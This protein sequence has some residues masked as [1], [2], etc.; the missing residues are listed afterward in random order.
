MAK[1]KKLPLE[2]EEAMLT[3]LEYGHEAA[4]GLA[5]DRPRSRL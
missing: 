2:V 1:K 4:R 3:I 5:H